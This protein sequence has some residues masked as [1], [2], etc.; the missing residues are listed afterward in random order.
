MDI[1]AHRSWSAQVGPVVTVDVGPVVGQDQVLIPAQQRLDEGLDG[2][3]VS[4]GNNGL[5]GAVSRCMM[6][7]LYAVLSIGC[8]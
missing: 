2:A 7:I 4:R 6:C 1:S 5:R 8:R 3:A